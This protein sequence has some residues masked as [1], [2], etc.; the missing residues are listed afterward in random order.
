MVVVH[1]VRCEMARRW[2]DDDGVE[3]SGLAM[4]VRVRGGDGERGGARVRQRASSGDSP[5]TH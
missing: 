2:E 1:A 5:T 3:L 4:A